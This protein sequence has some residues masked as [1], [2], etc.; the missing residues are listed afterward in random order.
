MEF[1]AEKVKKRNSTVHNSKMDYEKVNQK[2]RFY[3]ELKKIYNWEGLAFLDKVVTFD[4]IWVD[5]RGIYLI[6]R[7]KKQMYHWKKYLKLVQIIL[8]YKRVHKQFL[9]MQ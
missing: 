5:H 8:K 9:I 1:I 2:T 7:M 6:Y 4:E 3:T